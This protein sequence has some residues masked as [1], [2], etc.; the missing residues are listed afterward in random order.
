MINEFEIISKYFS[1]LSKNNNG[2]FNLRDDVFYDSK[3]K[4]SISVD[5]Y[6]EKIHFLNLVNQ[7]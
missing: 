2:A 4:I 6:N 3:K 5:T 1:K 7:I